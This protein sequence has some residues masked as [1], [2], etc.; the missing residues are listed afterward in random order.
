MADRAAAV[1]QQAWIEATIAWFRAHPEYALVVRVHPHEAEYARV[2]DRMLRRY[3][4]MR[5]AAPDNVR[6]ILPEEEV[7]TYSLMDMAAVGLTYGSTTGLE[8]ACQGL[9]VIHAGVGFYKSFGFTREVTGL[10]DIPR[11]LAEGMAAPRS[12]E[13]QRLAYRFAYQYF[14]GLSVPFRKVRVADDFIQAEPAYQHT[15]ELALHRDRDLD[16][17]CAY[18]LGEAELY[19]P[20]SP[21][22]ALQTPH[23]EDRFFAEQ[24]IAGLLEAARH[25][26]RRT[27]V[28]IEAA[29]LLRQIGLVRDAAAVYNAA[30]QRNPDKTAKY[31]KYTKG[32]AKQAELS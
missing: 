10:A 23:A 7:S 16:R 9:P 11:L 29:A 24:R 27:D 28:L 12:I 18:I 21:L 15:S 2:D 22:Q 4:A 32:N 8:M 1:G 26:P 6:L 14:I 5:D 17:L 3:R 30:L 13:I 31:A 25:D 20:P 19:P